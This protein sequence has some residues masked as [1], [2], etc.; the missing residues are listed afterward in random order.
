MFK[1]LLPVHV[2]PVDV[3]VAERVRT[4]LA[5]IGQDVVGRTVGTALPRRQTR[6][7]HV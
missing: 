3:V 5:A 7:H 4:E 2:G 6:S 1:L